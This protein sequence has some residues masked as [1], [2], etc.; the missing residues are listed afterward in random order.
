MEIVIIN[1]YFTKYSIHEKRIEFFYSIFF[2]I[3]ILNRNFKLE[4]LILLLII[5]TTSCNLK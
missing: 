1:F 3:L 5:S 2:L 4:K